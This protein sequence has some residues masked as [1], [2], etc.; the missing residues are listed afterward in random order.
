VRVL[1]VED[2]VN[3]AD[4]VVRGLARQGLTVEVAYD[5]DRALTLILAVSYDVVVLD[6]DVPGRSGDE[7]C[8]V[9]RA[10][11]LPAK[12]LM[13]TASVFTEDRAAGYALGADDYLTKPFAFT[14]L[15][16]R[17]LALGTDGPPRELVE[18]PT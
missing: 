7:L 16:D 12:V 4:A 6:R 14:E 9:I 10:R 5:G 15:V 2:E 1:V 3:L 17:V 11:G 13:L 18:Q 8:Q